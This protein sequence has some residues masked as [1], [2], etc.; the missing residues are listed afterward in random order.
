[1]GQAGRPSWRRATRLA[2]A[3]LVLA[4]LV[5]PTAPGARAQDGGAGRP[6]ETVSPQTPDAPLVL[7]AEPLRALRDI[8]YAL[9]KKK[10]ADDMRELLSILRALGDDEAVLGKLEGRCE[11]ALALKR[12]GRGDVAAEARKL[13]A[14]A[15]ALGDALADVDASR[16]AEAGA[17]IVRIDARV[18]SAQSAVGRVPRGDGFVAA[19]DV[20]LLERRSDIEQAFQDARRF[21]VEI[22]S[23]ESRAAP[24]LDVYGRPGHSVRWRTVSLHSV[25]FSEERL[26]RVLTEAVR[27]YALA[28]FIRTVRL[29]AP[30]PQPVQFVIWSSREDHLKGLAAA[31]RKGGVSEEAAQRMR[32]RDSEDWIDAR[33]YYVSNVYVEVHLESVLLRN[34]WMWQFHGAH[35]AWADDDVQPCLMLGHLNWISERFL[36]GRIPGWD[37]Y[38]DP[39]R[40]RTS[41]EMSRERRRLLRLARTG[42]AGVRAYMKHLAARG[43]DPAWARSFVAHAGELAGEDLLKSMLVVEYLQERGE[44]RDV[45]LRT[46]KKPA[47]QKT[48]EDALGM[49]LLAFEQAWRE[50]LLAGDA[51]PSLVERMA[52]ASAPGAAGAVS[53]SA[54]EAVEVLNTIRATAVRGSA[55]SGSAAVEPVEIEPTLA[56]GC[57]SHARYLAQNPD[58]GAAWPAAHE[59]YVDRPGYSPEGVRAAASSVIAPGVRSAKD[60]VDGW[61]ATFYHRLPL[62]DPGL[63]R[64][65]WGMENGIAVMD[66]SSMVERSVLPALVVYPP[67]GGRDIP[68]RFAPELPSPL[69]GGD[70]STW[71]YPVTVQVFGE[72]EGLGELTVTL[73][74]GGADG[75]QV[76]CIVS[77]PSAPSNPVLAPGGAW[78][79]IPR[80]HLAPAATY[81]IRIEGLPPKPAARDTYTF[82]TAR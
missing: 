8:A 14:A 24:L 66:S 26:R 16:R 32:E 73:H 76:P 53:A 29:H 35:D 30:P 17:A 69:P 10:R 4:A 58:Q 34:L 41:D 55:T 70:Q 57:A 74:E 71:G 77:T 68:R 39:L 80:A 21:E 37:W 82:K 33:G 72:W 3:A 43:E 23:G 27:A 54:R 7:P 13:A 65:G 52:G 12:K 5:V 25:T 61:M 1:M 6:P 28:M 75:P 62:L 38:E 63:L 40:G 20:P 56:A 9:A 47:T 64:I 67:D 19:S 81:T 51:P 45:L 36:G 44:F 50:W 31:V 49:P 46:L 15:A 18:A 42:V 22:T 60:A 11:R 79:L 2:A 59:E 78:C 48:F